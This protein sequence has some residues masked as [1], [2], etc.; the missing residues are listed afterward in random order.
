MNDNVT[1]RCPSKDTDADVKSTAHAHYSPEVL[2]FPVA[3]AFPG[4]LIG[5]RLHDIL[6]SLLAPEG[7]EDPW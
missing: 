7:L 4:I 3:Q 2:V 1:P 5:R 6:A